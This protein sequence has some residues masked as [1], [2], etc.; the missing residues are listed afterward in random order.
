VAAVAA[1]RTELAELAAAFYDH[2]SRRLPVIGITGTDG[3]T[4][5]THL[6]S[7]VLEAHGLRTGWLTTVN[8]RIGDDVRPNAVDHTTPEAPV[9]QRTLSE[10]VD[11]GVD[12][13]ILET[14]SH[15]LALDRVHAVDF[16]VGVFTNLSPEHINFHGSF[17]EYRAAKSLLFQRLPEAGLA[18]LNADDPNFSH[19]RAATRAGVLTY[20]L[21][22][23]ADLSASH[24]A[25]SPKGAR[26]SL[27]GTPINTRLIG[28]FNVANWLAA[29]GAA[30][31]FGATLKDLCEAAAAQSPV[32]G[33]MNVVDAGQPF[34]VVIDFAHTPQALERALD[35]LRDLGARRVFLVFGLAGGRDAANRPVM[36]DLAARKSDFF[37]ISMDDPGHEDPAQI[38]QQIAAGAS[39]GSFEIE[40]DR[41][42]AIRKVLERAQPG[43]AV[44]LAGKGH[45]QRMV[46]GDARRPWNDARAAVEALAELGYTGQAVP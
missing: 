28:G 8:T 22:G 40:L 19:F 46:V 45:E 17:E 31:Y 7:A 9:V 15:A 14:S 29:F 2:P 4:T 34:S 6:L 10:M 32:P 42:A 23:P 21:D 41:R 35:T 33:R 26:F 13:C 11:G 43:D 5:T 30:T 37:V 18:V 3:K 38:A 24:V 16:K 20:A 1:S 44:L 39:S 27:Q 36:G 12:V 25:L